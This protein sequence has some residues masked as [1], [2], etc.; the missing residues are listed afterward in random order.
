M[1]RPMSVL[2]QLKGVKKSYAQRTGVFRKKKT[3]VLDGVD[4][5]IHRNHVSGVVGPSGA[6][7]STLARLLLKLEG[8]DD[9]DILLRGRSIRD[10]PDKDYYRN[11]R[12]MFQNPYSAVNPR[13]SI[14]KIISEPLRIAG[15]DRNSI[16]RRLH[17]LLDLVGLPDSLLERRPHQ[18]SG[19]QLQR[20]VLARTLSTEPEF[21]VLDEPFSSLDELLAQ[22]LARDFKRIFRQLELTVLLISHHRQ[23]M[24]SMADSTVR[25]EGGKIF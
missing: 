23:R 24:Q 12:I 20:A 18:V 19:G 4:L 5:E 3:P 9:G 10:I 16:G 22:R 7:K 17:E 8:W 6:G 1:E 15:Y 2:F 14:E 21:I 25:L 13:F 11:N